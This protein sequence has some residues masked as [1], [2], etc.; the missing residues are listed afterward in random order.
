M[1]S[2]WG[3]PFFTFILALRVEAV[4]ADTTRRGCAK[5]AIL[6]STHHIPPLEEFDITEY[7]WAQ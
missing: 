4:S 2:P 7:K 5:A 6:V 3:L 1:E